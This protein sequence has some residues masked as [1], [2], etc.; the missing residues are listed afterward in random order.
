MTLDLSK[1]SPG[2]RHKLCLSINHL[3]YQEYHRMKEDM[4]PYSP[5]PVLDE[6]KG[7]QQAAFDLSLEASDV[8]KF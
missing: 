4:E 7:W 5:G 8:A 3:A 1:L 6:M 2:F